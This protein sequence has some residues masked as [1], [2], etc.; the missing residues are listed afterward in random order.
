MFCHLSPYSDPLVHL[1]Y[2]W[3][4]RHQSHISDDSSNKA[5]EAKGVLLSGNIR[6]DEEKL[7]VVT[8]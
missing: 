4:S 6:G 8:R 3:G 5:G 1:G 7:E 2:I